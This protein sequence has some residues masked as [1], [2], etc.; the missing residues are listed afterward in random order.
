MSELEAAHRLNG[1]L[2]ARNMQLTTR[3]RE[4]EA[5]HAKAE[6]RIKAI[7]E[8]LEKNQPNVFSRGIWDAVVASQSDAAIEYNAETGHSEG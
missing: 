4:L 6:L 8:W 7:I 1:D 5:E 2:A 3:I